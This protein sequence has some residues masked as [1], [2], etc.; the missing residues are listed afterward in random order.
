LAE[1][2]IGAQDFS[3]AVE[4]TLKEYGLSVTL[5]MNEAV[6]KVGNNA[7][8]LLKDT[9]PKRKGGGKYAKSWVCTKTSD[10]P[11]ETTVI[12]H[13]KKHYRLTH[14]LENGHA[15]RNGGRTKAQP[16]IK[17]AEEQAI[18]EFIKAAKE[19]IDGA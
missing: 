5:R 2:K 18:S 17:P 16:H 3:K 4:N 9:S 1:L 6:E 15:T 8:D 14:L 7:A 13:N 12:V 10:S 11:L 19:A